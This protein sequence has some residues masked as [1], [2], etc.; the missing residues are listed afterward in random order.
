MVSDFVITF[1]ALV[2]IL[3]TSEEGWHTRYHIVYSGVR[4]GINYHVQVFLR[5]DVQLVTREGSLESLDL[6]DTAGTQGDISSLVDFTGQ[7]TLKGSPMI[8]NDL[9]FIQLCLSN[10]DGSG[11]TQFVFVLN[12]DETILFCQVAL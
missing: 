5:D 7:T 4:T 8:N 3:H 2:A 1:L 10:D 6:F 9:H 12:L 11:T